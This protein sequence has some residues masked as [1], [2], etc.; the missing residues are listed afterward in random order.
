MKRI[1]LILLGAF[2]CFGLSAQTDP[3]PAVLGCFVADSGTTNVRNAPN[4]LISGR[5]PASGT[6]TLA[7]YNPTDGWWQILNGVVEEMDGEVIEIP[8]EAWIHSSVIGLSTR[9][10]DRRALPLRSEPRANAAV[11]GRI[12]LAEDL[13]RPLDLSA[14]GKWV[15]V[16]WGKVSGWIEAEWLCGN[17]V[18]TCP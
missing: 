16:R 7:V 3:G 6:Y 8:E 1:A 18:T 4:G 9:N 15:K 10:Y 2:C 14:D 12:T 13:V 11:S 5:L 17:P